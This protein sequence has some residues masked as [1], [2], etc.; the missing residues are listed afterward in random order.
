MSVQTVRT[1]D[2]HL[3]PQLGLALLAPSLAAAIRGALYAARGALALA[4]HLAGVHIALALEAG[5]LGV[6][7]GRV[8]HARR[9]RA[10]NFAGTHA[11][12]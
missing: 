5:A 2:L 1:A 4:G 12:C 11:A 7:L 9:R 8:C 6:V 3:I 10:C